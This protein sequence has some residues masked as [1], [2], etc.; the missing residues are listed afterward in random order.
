LLIHKVVG[1][2]IPQIGRKPSYLSPYLLHLYRHYDYI[3][4]DEEDLLTI[5]A[6]E[7]AYKVRPVVGDSNTSS[8]SIIP[9][10]PPSLPGRPPPM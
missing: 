10:A 3:T 4:T 8:D 6:E 9:D 1:R 5:A 7:V 2:A